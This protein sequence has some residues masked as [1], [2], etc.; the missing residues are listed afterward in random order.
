[1]PEQ[2]RLLPI[3]LPWITSLLGPP[4]VVLFRMSTLPD[5]MSETTKI[6]TGLEPE[7]ETVPPINELSIATNPAIPVKDTLPRMFAAPPV[8]VAG[9]ISIVKAL[10]PIR[11]PLMTNL[12]LDVNASDPFAPPSHCPRR[13]LYRGR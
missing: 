4:L 8:P 9:V 5:T 12:A 7:T 10:V 1:L 6:S 13:P 11:E 2:T 3:V